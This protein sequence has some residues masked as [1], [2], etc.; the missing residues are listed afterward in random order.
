MAYPPSAAFATALRPCSNVAHVSCNLTGFFLC[1]SL[2]QL[3]RLCNATSVVPNL[4]TCFGKVDRCY[5]SSNSQRLVVVHEATR[6]L[7]FEQCVQ[8]FTGI[9]ESIQPRPFTLR[10]SLLYPGVSLRYVV[11][12]VLSPTDPNA[13]VSIYRTTCSVFP[14]LL[15]S[16]SVG[17]LGV[18]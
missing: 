14:P 8:R 12:W 1:L 5:V 11:F 17:S 6:R 7:G 16:V 13:S 2:D 4:R 10:S 18:Q 9:V 3:L 15:S